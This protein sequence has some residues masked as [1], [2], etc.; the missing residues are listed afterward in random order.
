[1]GR[2]VAL[3]MS[4]HARGGRIDRKNEKIEVW[5]IQR[6]KLEGYRAAYLVRAT[7][8]HRSRVSVVCLPL[9]VI[10]Y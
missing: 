4:I 8:P 3:N 1:M 6:F 10:S 2:Q 9:Y 5:K 7:P